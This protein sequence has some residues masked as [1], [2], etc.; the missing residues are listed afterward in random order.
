MIGTQIPEIERLMSTECPCGM[1]HF[2]PVKGI[3]SGKGVINELPSVLKEQYNP[4]K[5]FVLAD[6]NTYKAAGEKV[7]TLLEE[8]VIVYT[9][10]VF[11]TV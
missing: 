2:S 9:K 7:C 8:C 10:Y 11:D 1:K 6:K 4:S 5:V 3:F